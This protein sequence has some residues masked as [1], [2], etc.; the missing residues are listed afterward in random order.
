MIYSTIYGFNVIRNRSF[1]VFAIH[2]LFIR[3]WQTGGKTIYLIMYMCYWESCSKSV[4]QYMALMWFTVGHSRF[5]QYFYLKSRNRWHNCLHCHECYWGRCSER[6]AKCMALMW[7]L[8]SHLS[9]LQCIYC[10]LEIEKHVAQ[11]FILTCMVLR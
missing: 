1:K 8:S 11:L 5:L 2:I 9:F 7:F 6:V 4:A 3:N 10:S